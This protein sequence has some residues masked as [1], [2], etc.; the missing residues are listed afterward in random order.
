M[1]VRFEQA[2]KRSGANAYSLAEVLVGFMVFGVVTAG[3]IYGYVEANRVAEWSSQSQ[4]A[5]SLAVQGMEKARAAQWLAEEITITNG[6]N[7][8]DVMPL[9]LNTNTG[10]YSYSFPPEIDY[11]DVPMSGDLIPVTN[12]VTVTQIHTNPML[13][14]IVSQVTWTFLLTGKQYT[15]SMITLR[16]PDQFQ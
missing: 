9:T 7:T 14:Q 15:V 16:A 1:V 3:M 5:T 10:V 12:Y 8:I 11:M 4:A 13:R 2:G 6:P